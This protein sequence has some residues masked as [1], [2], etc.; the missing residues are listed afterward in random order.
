MLSSVKSLLKY[1]SLLR[2]TVTNYPR[3]IY[4]YKYITPRIRGAY[5]VINSNNSEEPGNNGN[6]GENGEYKISESEYIDI[7]NR[8]ELKSIYNELQSNSYE[9]NDPKY[10]IPR[11]KYLIYNNYKSPILYKEIE[12][13]LLVKI[14]SLS[15]NELADIILIYSSL[16]EGLSPKMSQMVE[17]MITRKIYEMGSEE[18]SRILFAISHAG[19]HFLNTRGVVITEC[20]NMMSGMGGA[21]LLRVLSSL[22][23]LG[24]GYNHTRGNTHITPLFI[25]T[26][27]FTLFDSAILNTLT[28]I[29]LAIVVREWTTYTHR[30]ILQLPFPGWEVINQRLG[31][32]QFEHIYSI[33]RSI[34]KNKQ[35]IQGVELDFELF[36]SRMFQLISSATPTECK[37]L[38]ESMLLGNSD[39][40]DIKYLGTLC[41]QI[42][43]DMEEMCVSELIAFLFPLL[44]V[45]VEENNNESNNNELE[46]LKCR[47]LS[48]IR[49]HS[50]L[51]LTDITAILYLETKISKENR[52][53]VLEAIGG[54]DRLL[55]R[56]LLLLKHECVM[57]DHAHIRE[58]RPVLMDHI[59]HV[60]VNLLFQLADYAASL[61]SHAL[62]INEG[63]WREFFAYLLQC[64][65]PQ[66]VMYIRICAMLDA[67]GGVGS[68]LGTMALEHKALLVQIYETGIG[69]GILE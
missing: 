8:R 68:W 23:G 34:N 2:R 58:G 19:S 31:D 50:H 43:E 52:G 57:C 40:L 62:L 37:F 29:Q 25:H 56:I 60:Y 9:L 21:Q 66:A 42:S 13:K 55:E 14:S 12:K 24:G 46:S 67:L 36:Y 30:G 64:K 33:F 5:S 35:T 61:H 17:H 1:N 54:L 44:L 20:M 27:F 39:I 48:I 32:F 10:T 45:N 11:L 26:L 51:S 41:K 18:L 6:N 22:D 69:I 59:V 7:N 38:L 16:P 65:I 4:K 3:H 63:F 47:I 28:H 49:K 15:P 53:A